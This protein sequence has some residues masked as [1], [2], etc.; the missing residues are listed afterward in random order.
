MINSSNIILFGV[1]ILIIFVLFFTSSS[2]SQTQIAK[3][4]QE[5]FA[6][7][8]NKPV[9]KYKIR[10]QQNCP[11]LHTRKRSSCYVPGIAKTER[12]DN[13]FHGDYR[14]TITAINNLVPGQK[15]LFNIS[16]RPLVYSEPEPKE[17]FDLVIDFISVLNDNVSRIVPEERNSNS[18]WDEAIPDPTVE[19]GWD[20]AQK[21]LGLTPSLYDKP[22]GRSLVRLIKINRVQKYETDDEI[23]YIIEFIVQKENVDDQMI[24]KGS[25]VQDKRALNNEDE[26]FF[27]KTV[28]LRIIIEEMWTL[29]YLT[30]SMFK[31]TPI[32]SDAIKDD[33][34]FNYDDMERNDLTDPKEIQK[35]LMDKYKQRV[36][37]MDFRNAML[38]EEGQAMHRDL[39]NVYDFSNIKGTRTIFDDMNKKKIFY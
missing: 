21:A 4:R 28:E 9:I 14:D 7:L 10:N 30:D 5:S 6:P 11:T 34:Y 32:A 26:F 31:N 39:P 12:I 18:G 36:Q 35:I 17:V 38:D 13:Q 1:V 22:S 15:Q 33:T 27:D 19:S 3:P 37:E 29:G 20:K 25:F 8:Q 16:N 24:L 2:K 23:R